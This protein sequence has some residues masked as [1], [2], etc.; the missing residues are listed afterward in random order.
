MAKTLPK[1]QQVRS[2]FPRFGVWDYAKFKA[3]ETDSFSITIG[4]D[5]DSFTITQDD[6]QKLERIEQVSDFHCVTTWSYCDVHWGGYRFRD[7]YE[8]FIQPTLADNQ[9]CNI[10]MFRGRI[11]LNRVCFWKMP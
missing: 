5:I 9:S 1:G 10:I 6:L 7:F 2:D 11:V 8:Q 4:G 3:Q